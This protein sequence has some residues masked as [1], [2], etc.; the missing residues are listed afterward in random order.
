MW[1][2]GVWGLVGSGGEWCGVFYFILEVG[3]MCKGV[4]LSVSEAF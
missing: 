2:W 1:V 3:E 4:G